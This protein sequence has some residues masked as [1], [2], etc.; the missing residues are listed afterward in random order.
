[1]LKTTECCLCN[2]IAGEE[3]NDLIARLLQ[4]EP[5][6][7]RVMLESRSFAAIPSLGPLVSGHTLLCP[8]EAYPIVKTKK[9]DN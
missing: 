7:R 3:A 2:Q 6:V 4:G 1:M 8:N 5:Y 9:S